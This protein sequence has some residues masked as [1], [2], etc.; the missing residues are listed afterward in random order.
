[1]I[2]LL[3]EITLIEMD[4]C[5]NSRLLL[6]ICRYFIFLSHYIDIY[7]YIYRKRDISWYRKRFDPFSFLLLVIL[8]IR[9]RIRSFLEASLY[10]Y[11]YI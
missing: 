7:I 11:I 3:P 1:M 6:L 10:I 4:L 5:F 2:D 8:W 9:A